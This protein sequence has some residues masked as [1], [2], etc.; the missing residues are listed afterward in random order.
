MTIPFAESRLP[1]FVCRPSLVPVVVCRP[2][3]L[4]AA[5]PITWP[6]PDLP[7]GSALISPPTATRGDCPS[8]P[9]HQ[10]PP[11]ILLAPLLPS[12]RRGP[13]RP[14]VECRRPSRA[15]P[16][17]VAVWCRR[18][19]SPSAPRPT[20]PTAAAVVVVVA[21]APA[22][23][24][25]LAPAPRHRPRRRRRRR[26]CRYRRPRTQC[27]RCSR[28]TPEPIVSRDTTPS[29]SLRDVAPGICCRRR[30]LSRRPRPSCSPSPFAAMMTP[31]PAESRPTS[32]SPPPP[33]PNQFPV[34]A[35]P[36]STH[37]LADSFASHPPPPPPA[38]QTISSR[39]CAHQT[40]STEA[41]SRLL[42]PRCLLDPVQSAASPPH[43][44]SSRPR[45]RRR[46][47]SPPAS[48]RLYPASIPALLQG[49]HHY[50]QSGSTSIASAP[51]P[52][53][54]LA[55]SSALPESSATR[56]PT[57]TS[58]PLNPNCVNSA[59]RVRAIQIALEM[60]SS[61]LSAWL[62]VFARFRPLQSYN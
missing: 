53:L 20:P 54:I 8:R 4:P 22:Q 36:R 29:L 55:C 17:A 6:R 61:N 12:Q 40:P 26:R 16:P 35:E 45:R 14:V 31:H 42:A 18:L 50:Q 56:P 58:T 11:T 13:P 46:L 39:R 41:A 59:G 60:L 30:P 19:L 33:R 37:D 47:Q 10:P 49:S 5:A 3:L 23:S 34:H 52:P 7:L 21:L 57:E 48:P 44:S 32:V 38:H 28:P 43:P 24:P 1:H 2:R 27:F 15:V 25:T 62:N 9:L 51:T